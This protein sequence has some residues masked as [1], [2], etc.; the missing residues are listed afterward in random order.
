M[1][2]GVCDFRTIQVV[3][4]QASSLTKQKL[5]SRIYAS[6]GT[7]R[8]MR[9]SVAVRNSQN[10]AAQIVSRRRH[11]VQQSHCSGSTHTRA[12]STAS[13][14]P[15]RTP[16]RRRPA[17]A[18]SKTTTR[19]AQWP[20]KALQQTLNRHYLDKQVLTSAITSFIAS[21]AAE[22]SCKRVICGRGFRRATWA[23]ELALSSA[24]RPFRLLSTLI[25]RYSL[26]NFASIP[27]HNRL[28][29]GAFLFRWLSRRIRR[30]NSRSR[31]SSRVACAI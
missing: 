10:V 17:P 30:A 18:R 19:T 28:W 9:S 14:C 3:Y 8:N 12:G 11:K 13:S 15:Q 29:G 7:G 4:Q 22:T 16:G 31:C 5:Q 25:A 24:A 1:P 20:L 23:R 26:L 27:I 2:P 6:A 21:F